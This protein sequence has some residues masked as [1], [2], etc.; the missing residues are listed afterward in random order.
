MAYAVLPATYTMTAGVSTLT[1]ST[2]SDNSKEGR[3]E[4]E[5]VAD[6]AAGAAGARVVTLDTPDTG[7]NGTVIVRSVPNTESL[8]T[9]DLEPFLSAPRTA[10]GAATLYDPTSFAAYVTRQCAGAEKATTLWALYDNKCV[11]A[12][13]NDHLPDAPGWRDHTASLVM[14]LD[15][16][17]RAWVGSNGNYLRQEQFG[18]FLMDQAHVIVDPPAADLIGIAT[19]FT[20]KKNVTFES[21]IRQNSGD[22]RFEFREDTTT[23]VGKDKVD[24]P[25]RFTIRLPVFTGSDETVELSARLRWKLRG[26]DFSI[27]YKLQRPDIAERQAFNAI[28]TKIGETTPAGVQVLN[29]SRPGAL[30]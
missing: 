28:V 9:K 29:G 15:Q 2:I 12:V 26:D 19:T 13:F 20:A 5:V 23:R 21:A 17:W 27:G 18:E 7:V 4:A 11:D 16:D 14:I 30:R 1:Y 25:E 6:L 22:V 24:I 8:Q 10:R 3:N